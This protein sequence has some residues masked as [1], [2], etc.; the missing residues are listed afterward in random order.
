[1]G[2]RIDERAVHKDSDGRYLCIW[3]GRPLPAGSR[4]RKYCSDACE[5]EYLVRRNP[6]FLRQAVMNRDH[7]VCARCGLDTVK[8]DRDALAHK[9]DWTWQEMARLGRWSGWDLYVEQ[10]VGK[11]WSGHGAL[12]EAHHKV[13]VK[14]GGDGALENIETL[15]YWCHKDET[16]RQLAK[17]KPEPAPLPLFDMDSREG[18]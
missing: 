2:R 15:C 14:D 8:L 16:R 5:T 4:R 1:M 10:T 3:C 13:A 11:P 7:G 17:P 6:G 9:N 12:W 18:R